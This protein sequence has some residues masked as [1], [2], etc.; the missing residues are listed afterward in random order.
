MP[1]PKRWNGYRRKAVRRGQ[2]FAIAHRRGKLTAFQAQNCSPA[3]VRLVMG[4]Y[5]IVAEIGAGGMG[6]VYKAQHQRMKR[7]VALKVMSSAAMKDAAAVKRFQR[8]VIAAARLEHPN[9]VTA[10]DSGEAGSV[11]YLVMQF[12]DGG[13]LSDLVKKNG[14]LGVE[15]AV[16]YV[17]QAA[18]GFPLRMAR[19]SCIATS[20]RPTCCS[21]KRES[22]RFSIWA[23]PGSK[24]ATG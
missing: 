17:I 11:K 24:T 7:V 4:D 20:S 22:S 8:E 21:I 13:D 1:R 9:I 6:Q 16:G 18:R 19:V 3:A 2:A 12:V 23:W 14:P 15:R 10:Y 5:V